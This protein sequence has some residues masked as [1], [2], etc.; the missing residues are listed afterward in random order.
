MTLNNTADVVNALASLGNAILSHPEEVTALLLGLL[1]ILG[2]V[3]GTAGGGAVCLSGVGCLAGG[4]AAAA[5]VALVAAGATAVGIAGSS[6]IQHAQ[7]DSSMQVMNRN[8]AGGNGGAAEGNGLSASEQRVLKSLEDQRDSHVAKLDAY[9]ANPDAYDNRGLLENAATPEI[10]ESI[11]SGRINHLE[12]EIRGFQQQ[13]DQL[14]G[15][16]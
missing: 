7:T 13:I 4:P 1:G 11:I 16:R 3:G 2:G 6:L 15:R 8:S 9:R 14:R 12:K 5:S 10:R